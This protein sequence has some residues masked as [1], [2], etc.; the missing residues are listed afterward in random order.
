M[1]KKKKSQLASKQPS[2][3]SVLAP[4]QKIPNVFFLHLEVLKKGTGFDKRL[5]GKVDLF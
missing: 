5:V 1:K 2:K 4:S 3:L